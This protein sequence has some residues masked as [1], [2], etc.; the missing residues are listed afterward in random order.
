VGWGVFWGGWF[1]GGGGGGFVFWGDGDSM[2]RSFCLTNDGAMV[3]VA[4]FGKRGADKKKRT[5]LGSR[6]LP[7]GSEKTRKTRTCLSK[8]V[9][10]T[11]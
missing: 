1:V 10:G 5:V 4:K 9:K 8:S 3:K 2:E 7:R 6:P 11:K